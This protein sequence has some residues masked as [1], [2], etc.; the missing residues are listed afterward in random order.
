MAKLK[1]APQPG[2]QEEFL[3]TPAD[4]GI[5]GGAAG[6]GKT[7]ALQ[8]EPTRHIHVPTF[9]GVIYRKIRPEIIGEGGLWQKAQEIYPFLGAV[10]RVSNLSFRW[11]PYRSSIRFG[12]LNDEKALTSQQGLQIP[13][14]GFDQLEHFSGR[15]FWYMLSRN[16][17][18]CGIRPYVRATCNPDPDSFLRELLDWWIDDRPYESIPDDYKRQYEDVHHPIGK[19]FPRW[20]RSGVVRCFLRIQNKLVWATSKDI[21]AARFN[22]DI[23]TVKSLTF[24][25]GNVYDNKKLLDADPEYLG[26]LMAQQLVDRERLLRGN[27]DVRES[28][29]MFFRRGWWKI[30]DQAPQKGK[31]VRYWDRAATDESQPNYKD[32]SATAGCKML[33]TKEGDFYILHMEHF[34]GSPGKV[35][36]TIR[37]IAEQDGPRVTIGIEKDPAQAGKMEAETQIKNLAGFHALANVPRESKANRAKPL[38]AQAEAGNV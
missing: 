13:F 36:S 15:Q 6:A 19:G 2:P 26:N 1:L 10:E 5:Y 28:A 34:W 29:G 33:K 23:R 22:V 7:Y 11:K 37:N 3:S 38:S 17:S 16:R 32:A 27:W 14:I 31:I 9:T 30:V 35:K 8:L 12:Y 25:A 24:V 21:L 18:T 20:D 4:I